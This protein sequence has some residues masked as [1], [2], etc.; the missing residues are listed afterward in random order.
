VPAYEGVFSPDGTTF[1]YRAIVDAAGSISTRIDG[2]GY[3][4]ELYLQEPVGGHGGPPPGR[5][6]FDQ[7]EF[8][9]DGNELLDY[10]A[11]R[12]ASG[13]ANFLVYR[14]SGILGTYAPPD[15]FRIFQSTTAAYGA[16]A[17]TGSTLYLFAPAQGSTGEV[18][19]LDATGRQLTLARGV[20]GFFW[21][22]VMASG[23]SIVY[24][25]YVSPPADACGGLPHLWT[26]DLSAHVASQLSGAIS[27]HPVLAAR[28]VVWSNEEKAGQCGPGGE[29]LPDGVILARDLSTGRD[30]PVNMDAIVPGIG[31]PV[32]PPSTGQ[33]L[34]VWF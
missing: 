15:S 22:Q 31:S 24:D 32:P 12:G 3:D 6:P 11:F 18:D 13:P 21:P 17:R 27:S 2:A 8:S 1:V 7:L 28:T 4:R 5:G 33:V 14:T 29:S 16:W 20:P 25:T 26:F 23:G 30:S 34:D 9:A 10:S 19:S